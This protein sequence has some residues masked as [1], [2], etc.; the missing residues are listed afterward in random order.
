LDSGHELVGQ[1]VAR[2]L[3]LTPT[4]ALALTFLMFI[5]CER[6]AAMSLSLTSATT[7]LMLIV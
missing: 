3:T 4:P 2:S 1:L 5:S 7:F 6:K